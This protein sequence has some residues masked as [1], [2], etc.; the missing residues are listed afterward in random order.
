VERHELAAFLTLAE[1]LHFGRTAEKLGVTPGRVSQIIQK[2]ER[3]IGTPLFERSSRRAELTVVGKTLREDLEP[4][5]RG[6][7]EAVDRAVA[8]GRGITGRLRVGYLGPLA[9]G[10]VLEISRSFRARMPECEV[11]I[12]ES[13]IADPCRPLREG[14]VDVMLTQFPVLEEGLVQGP[15]LVS[16]GRVLAVSSRHPFARRAGVS[17]E[18]VARDK[19]FG[20]GGTPPRDWAESHLPQRTPKGLPIERRHSVFTFQELLTLI[21]AGEGICPVAAHNVRY[22]LRPDIAYIPMTDAPPF[23]FGLVWVGRNETATVRAFARAAVAAVA[24]RG[25]PAAVG[26]AEGS[27]EGSS[28]E[29]SVAG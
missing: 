1:E 25:G 2:L 24:T 14:E 6:I 21:A 10:L 19:T 9:G 27:A 17:L 7:Q 3:R 29:N 28:A 12:R 23:E 13:T 22:N 18:D 26:S 15:L 16:E 5:Y 11:Q 4:H 20:P 8:A